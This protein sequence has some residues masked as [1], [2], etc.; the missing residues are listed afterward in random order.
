MIE[1]FNKLIENKI[2]L[3]TNEKFT[4]IIGRNPSKTAR[5]PILWNKAFKNFNL[6]LKMIPIDVKKENLKY[7][8]EFLK[9]NKKFLGGSVT[10]PYKSELID[11]LEGNISDE[12]NKIGAINSLF[13]KK[14]NKLY[15]TN[16]DGE[17]SV[18]AFK[19]K[20][21]KFKD[22]KIMILGC[23]GA[24]KAVIAFFS[25]EINGK[26]LFITSR[27]KKN[28]LYSKK[29]KNTSWIDWNKKDNFFKN[30]DIIINCTSLGFDNQKNISPIEEKFYNNFK[31][32]V[33]FYDIIYNP[34]QTKFLELAQKNKYKTINDSEMNIMQAA[35]S[36]N[37]VVEKNIDEIKEAMIN[38]NK[39]K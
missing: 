39:N 9:N 26:N 33:I 30:L 22:K 2:N 4:V 8:I 25:K 16:T 27:N 15:G 23:G 6:N 17:A 14:N 24:G 1:E 29:F 5:S 3:N 10:I 36:F 31:S 18:E 28:E 21:G 32:G 35:I 20:F 12:A 11:F 19:K 37:Y 13:R 7:L 34:P 38:D